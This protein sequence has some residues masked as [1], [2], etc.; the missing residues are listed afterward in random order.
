MG[1]MSFFATTCETRELHTD[2]DLRTRYYRNNFKQCLEALKQFAETNHLEVRNINTEH[3]EIYLLGNGFDIIVT[4]IQVTPVEAGI[5]LKINFFAF[6]G[7]GRPKKKAVEFYKYL[8]S[9]LNFKGM[10][11]HP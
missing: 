4:I 7:L 3:G 10:S 5:D 6:S 2:P 11:L 9:K 1:I 8:D